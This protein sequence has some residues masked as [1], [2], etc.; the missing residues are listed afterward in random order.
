[1]DIVFT[2]H[3]LEKLSERKITKQQVIITVRHP[4]KLI[5]IADKFYAF[6]QFGKRYLRVIFVREI[7]VIKIITQH[8]IDKL[9]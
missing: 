1:M 9:T 2:K 7:E 8:H 3:A 5:S 6:R 4:Q